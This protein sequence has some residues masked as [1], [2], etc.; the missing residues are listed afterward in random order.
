ME[1][2]GRKREAEEYQT[3]LEEELAESQAQ[4]AALLDYGAETE[5][6]RAAHNAAKVFLLILALTFPLPSQINMRKY[7]RT[8]HNSSKLS[9]PSIALS[10]S[11]S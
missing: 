2:G 5:A 8:A 1:E 4:R 6:L 3:H 10:L 11:P 7:A 9:S